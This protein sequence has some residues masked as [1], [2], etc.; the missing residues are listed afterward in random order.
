MG[1]IVQQLQDPV[2]VS[3][4]SSTGNCCNNIITPVNNISVVMKNVNAFIL[5]GK[6][7]CGSGTPANANVANALVVASIASGT[8]TSYY[9]GLTNSAGEY[10]ICVPSSGMYSVQAYKCCCS[11]FTTTDAN[12]DCTIPGGSTP[13]SST[14]E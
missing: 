10:S 1:C 3:V 5:R 2:S 11:T 8:G 14:S 13:G 4:S 9:V 7:T 6:V 12:C